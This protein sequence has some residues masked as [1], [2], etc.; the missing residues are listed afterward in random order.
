[1]LETTFYV[2][3]G[4]AAALSYIAFFTSLDDVVSGLAAAMV[5]AG[6]SLGAFNI[7]QVS[8]C[9]RRTTEEPLIGMLFAGFAA[10]MLYTMLRGSMRLLDPRDIDM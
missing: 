2:L 7:E 3:I 6:A 5:W 10:I 9:C 8:R 1:M 4:L